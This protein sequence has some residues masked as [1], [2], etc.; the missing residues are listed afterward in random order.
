MIGKEPT[1][2]LFPQLLAVAQ[3]DQLC[4]TRTG[5]FICG[6]ICLIIIN[7]SAGVLLPP[8]LSSSLQS[9]TIFVIFQM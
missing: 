9:R 3:S 1:L 4:Q 7:D 5:G 6:N 8:D 2:H